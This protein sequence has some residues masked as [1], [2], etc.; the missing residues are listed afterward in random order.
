MSDTPRSGRPCCASGGIWK[1]LSI[2]NGLRE[3]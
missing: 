1:G 2:M 3:A